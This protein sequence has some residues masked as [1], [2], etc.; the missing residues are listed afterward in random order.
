MLTALIALGIF[1]SIVLLT[2]GLYYSS[3]SLSKTEGQ[4]LKER[5]QNWNTKLVGQ[6]RHRPVVRKRVLSEIPWFHRVLER[7][8]SLATLRRWHEGAKE[9]NSLGAYILISLLLG[10]IGFI[11]GRDLL[12]GHILTPV[13]VSAV[14]LALPWLRLYWTRRQ[15]LQ[16]IQRQLPDAL[17]LIARALRAGHAFS[18]GLQ[19]VG[20]EMPD[21]IGAEF[22][23]TYEEITMGVSSDQALRNLGNRVDLV[24]VKFFVT[25]VNIQRETGGNLAEIL[26]ALGHLIR[27]RF[28]VLMKIK[29]L[30]AEGKISALVLFCLPPAMALAL[31]WISPGYIDVL[32]TDPLGQKM[33]IGATTLMVIGAFVTKK[34]VSMGV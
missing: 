17:E 11:I 33:L 8:R 23:R 26:E 12:G 24:D 30:S 31:N 20:D 21:P 6:P 1:A 10:V 16:N 27:R 29:A 18:V 14:G 19:M 25:S 13:I 4:R 15:H 2:E 3:H 28:E 7:S 32:F 22:K 34:M 9:H 5:V